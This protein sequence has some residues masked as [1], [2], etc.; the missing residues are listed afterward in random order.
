MKHWLKGSR[1][2][3]SE[4]EAAQ[5]DPDSVGRGE[6]EEGMVDHSVGEGS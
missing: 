3:S 5:G 1:C 6:S 2:L 4:V